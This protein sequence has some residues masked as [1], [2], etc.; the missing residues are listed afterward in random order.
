MKTVPPAK[1]GRALVFS[2]HPDDAEL[3]MGG[4]IAKL[5]RAG[6]QVWIV[7]FTNGE[8]TPFGSAQQRLR[9][10]EKAREILGASRRICLGMPNRYLECTLERRRQVAE[11]IRVFRPDILFGPVADW[12]PDHRAAVELVEGGRFEAKFTHVDMP[13][14]SC[15]VGPYFQYYSVHRYRFEAA[16]IAVDVSDSWLI[17]AAAVLAYESQERSAK[18]LGGTGLVERCEKAASHF[19]LLAGVKYAEAF[20]CEQ[21]FCVNDAGLLRL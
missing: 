3:G 2:P 11:V 13:G 15:W 21:L 6:W 18:E 7:D 4:T 9:E 16:S 8:P 1:S 10:A 19:G 17:K 12:H 5:V 14:D 20:I